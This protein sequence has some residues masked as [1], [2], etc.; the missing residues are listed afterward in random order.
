MQTQWHGS[1][2]RR[3][4]TF[5]IAATLFGVLSAACSSLPMERMR[6]TFLV[7]EDTVDVTAFSGDQRAGEG[8]N[9][10]AAVAAC[11]ERRLHRLERLGF[12]GYV[13]AM[14][15]E[16]RIHDLMP[17]LTGCAFDGFDEEVQDGALVETSL[18]ETTHFL[19]SVF[20]RGLCPN[21]KPRCET[22]QLRYEVFTPRPGAPFLEIPYVG[23]LP[24]VNSIHRELGSDTMPNNL[25]FYLGLPLRANGAATVVDTTSQSIG[26]G[27]F[28]LLW[29]EWNAYLTSLEFATAQ[30]A[31]NQCWVLVTYDTYETAVFWPSLVARYL[32]VLEQRFPAAARALKADGR[33]GKALAFQL[34]RSERSIAA[35]AK[36]E[37]LRFAV[38]NV[39]STE[40]TYAAAYTALRKRAARP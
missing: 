5:P 11:T 22:R 4:L 17:R 1:R 14:K 23:G 16:R 38:D 2:T 33:L 27:D 34:D 35:A 8:K 20:A 26:Q 12:T 39:A 25:R 21:R 19:G 9:T 30:A 40:A 3:A 13:Q 31:Q 15:A 7:H 36:Y 24:S 6:L 32:D 18:H 29:D 28:Y 37:C 10:P